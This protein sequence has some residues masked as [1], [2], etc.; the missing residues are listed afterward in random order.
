MTNL[1]LWSLSGLGIF[2]TLAFA[3]RRFYCPPQLLLLLAL[4]CGPIVWAVVIWHTYK[5]IQR[6]RELKQQADAARR[7]FQSSSST[8]HP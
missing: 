1:L 2:W 7:P 3:M 5:G 6:A 4:A 8:K